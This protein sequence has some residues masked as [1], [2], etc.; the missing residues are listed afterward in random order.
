MTPYQYDIYKSRMAKKDEENKK[1]R[2][3]FKAI[4]KILDRE[5]LNYEDFDRLSDI[6]ATLHK[7]GW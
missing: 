2:D 7:K 3:V 5:D 6:D 4:R 1:I